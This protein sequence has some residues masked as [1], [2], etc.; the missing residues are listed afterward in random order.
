MDE[1]ALAAARN[2][3]SLAPRFQDFAPEA[4]CTVIVEAVS[5]PRPRSAQG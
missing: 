2:G 4:L 3:F 1:R 5:R